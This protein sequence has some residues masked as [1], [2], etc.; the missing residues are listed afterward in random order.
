M[1]NII[2]LEDVLSYGGARKSTIELVS[3]LSTYMPVK[4]IDIN[5]SCLPF[6]RACQD[7]KVAIQVLDPKR[8]PLILSS[9]DI[10]K[11]I[12]NYICY[13][14]YA[15]KINRIIRK[16]TSNDEQNLF[17]VNN[18]RVL[19]FLLKKPSNA[20]IA[21]FARGWFMNRQISKIDRY[22]YRKLVDRYICVSESTRQAIY[23][24]GLA[25]L[26]SLFVVHNAI[27]EQSLNSNIY[28]NG[29]GHDC[30]KILLSG[31]FLP[32][33]GHQIAI[34]I[35]KELKEKGVTFKM[36]LTGI[37]YESPASSAFYEIIKRNIISS[38]LTDVVEIVVNKHD[39]I[40]Y[41][42]W[43]DVFIHPSS[44]EGLPRV[45]MEALILKKAVVANAVGGVTDYILDG[46]TGIIVNYNN[47]N[48]YV[49]GIL[50]LWNDK[51]LYK[52]ITENGYSLIKECFSAERQI[53]AMRRALK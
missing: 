37:I 48:D 14:F 11:K 36:I 18:S 6:I 26:K 47:V 33:K 16:I 21:L 53:E 15:I 45:I 40:E 9:N 41:F 39:V 10:L 22:L 32:S 42:R 29:S 50:K 12:Y 17:V 5:G 25:D 24:A 2:F 8:S 44:T 38:G 52:K 51:E 19:L 28:E 35:A 3:R 13:I 31:G 7:A 4:I 30:L 46:F 49:A 27:D 23:G 20:Q 1:Y 34:E 43:C